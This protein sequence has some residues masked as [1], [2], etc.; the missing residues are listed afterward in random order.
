MRVLA[1]LLKVGGHRFVPDGL[2]L[3]DPD[4]FLPERLLASGQL[5]DTYL[6]ALARSEGAQLATF[7][8]RLVATGVPDGSSHVTL[9]A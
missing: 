4:H 1:S 7:D 9:I 3:L 8:R 5:T 2:S 6:L